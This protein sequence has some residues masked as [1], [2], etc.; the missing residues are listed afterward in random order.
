MKISEIIHE[1]IETRL[2]DGDESRGAYFLTNK[3]ACSCNAVYRC[4]E[5]LYV[6]EISPFLREMGVNTGGLQEF[7]DFPEGPARQQARAL[8]LTWAELMAE[9]EGL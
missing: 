9:E 1:A 7:D 8:W 2:W 4:D 3:H 6:Q 5:I